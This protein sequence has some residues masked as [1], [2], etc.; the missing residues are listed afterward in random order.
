MQ[1]RQASARICHARGVSMVLL[2]ALSSPKEI[3]HMQGKR[4]LTGTVGRWSAHHPWTAIAVWILF[5]AVA[6]FAGNAAGTNKVKAADS[7]AGESG[8]ASKVLEH[9][10]FA[11]EPGEQ[12]L[13]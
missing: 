3:W 1:R 6:V 4:G 12:I 11:V 2:R 13:V 8:K 10:G 5:I 9:A 7:G